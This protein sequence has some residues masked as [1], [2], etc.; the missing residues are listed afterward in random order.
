MRLLPLPWISGRISR[1]LPSSARRV[2]TILPGPLYGHYTAPARQSSTVTDPPRPRIELRPYQDECINA[3][4]ANVAQGG[5]RLGIS[6][7]TGSG[8]TVIFSHLIDRLSPPT[9]DA[10]Q[11][12]ILAHRRELVEQAASHCRNLYPEKTVEIDMGNERASGAADIT[13]ASVASLRNEDRL[14]N[15][16]PMRFKLLMIDEAHHA[17]A[18]SYLGIIKHFGLAAKEGKSPTTL[19]G[20]SATFF[21]PDGVSLGSAVDR[22]VYHR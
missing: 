22:I 7:A 21:R 13:I 17:A 1:N 16:D 14:S 9:R 12:L 4:L 18:P 8:K 20:V 19:V 6:L 11:T 3:V 2:K 15:Y 10:T 5:R